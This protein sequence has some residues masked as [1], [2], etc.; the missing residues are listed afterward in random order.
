MSAVLHKYTIEH[1]HLSINL[2]VKMSE[3]EHFIFTAEY[4]IDF[5]HLSYRLCNIDLSLMSQ[6]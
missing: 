5:T 2:L 4:H 6:T 3:H 1:I